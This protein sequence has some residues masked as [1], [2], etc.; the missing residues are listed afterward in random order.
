MQKRWMIYGAN[1]FT[2]R[3]IATEA[4]KRGM[5]PILAGR[6]AAHVAQLAQELDL[7]FRVFDLKDKVQ[8]VQ[9]LRTVKAVLHCAGPYAETAKPMLEACLEARTHYLDLTGEVDVFVELYQR[10]SEAERKRVVMCPGV[11]FDIIPTDCIA[12]A[13]KMLLPDANRLSLGFDPTADAHAS[14]GSIK[15]AFDMYKGGGRIRQD[16]D[17]NVVPIDYRIRV[18]DFGGGACKAICIPWG[19]VATAHFSTGIPNIEVYTPTSDN[20]DQSLSVLKMA[21]PLAALGPVENFFKKHIEK[22]FQAPEETELK[23][24]KTYVWGEVRNNSGKVI[25]AWVTTSNGYTVTVYGSLKVL[26]YVLTHELSGGYYTPSMMMGVN[27]VQEL[28][29]SSKITYSEY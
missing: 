11:G 2:G 16:G 22:Y 25:Q 23:T 13:L 6:S 3:L 17:I 18:I 5:Y 20:F 9:Q 12:T 19:D 26:E 27:L 24:L 8:L 4:R 15:T 10:R 28:P 7:P 14:I 1:G 21:R 29:G